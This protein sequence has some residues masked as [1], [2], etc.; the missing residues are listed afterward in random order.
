MEIEVSR[1]EEIKY[2]QD[3]NST[4]DC[5]LTIIKVQY[6]NILAKSWSVNCIQRPKEQAYNPNYFPSSIQDKLCTI[7]VKMLHRLACTFGRKADVGQLMFQ[8]SFW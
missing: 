8:T 2:K 7:N 3:I 4:A 1:A 6:L 5:H